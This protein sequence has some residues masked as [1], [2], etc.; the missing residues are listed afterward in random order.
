MATTSTTVQSSELVAYVHNV[1]P[2]KKGSY[3]ECLLQTKDAV[4]RGVCFSLPKAKRFSEISNATSPVKLKKFKVDTSSN[5]ED[6]LMDRNIIIEEVTADFPRRE[7]PTTTNL[8]SILKICVGQLTS[9][10][11]KVASIEPTKT[12]NKNGEELVLQEVMLV[13]PSGT[14][15]LVLWQE[16]VE[17]L[18][19]GQTYS[20]QD[21]R[22]KQNKFTKEIFINTSKSDTK[23]V[24]RCPVH[25]STC[26]WRNSWS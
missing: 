13:D 9:V 6:V 19:A 23:I 14:M 21:V 4:V 11:A 25:N 12:I 16:F 24:S 22:V 1:S 10:T 17:L 20:F 5:A 26:N 8:L 3:F 7:M 2:V 18:V 15:K